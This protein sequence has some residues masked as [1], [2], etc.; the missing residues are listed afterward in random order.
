[1]SFTDDIL[2]HFKGHIAEVKLVT[3]SGGVFEV[4]VNGDTLHSK[5]ETGVFPKSDDVIKKMEALN[6]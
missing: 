6:N 5:K 1:V 2:D 3:S 4:V